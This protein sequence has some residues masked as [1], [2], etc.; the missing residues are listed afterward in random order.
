LNGSAR[1]RSA[2]GEIETRRRR[3]VVLRLTRTLQVMVQQITERE[4]EIAQALDARPDGQIL[5]SFLSSPNSVICAATLLAEI[6]D[7]R[8]RYHYPHR[9]AI[10]ADGGQ[11][12]VAI[13]SGQAQERQV[14]V[15]AQ[16]TTAQR[17][18]HAGA[19]QP[20]NGPLGGRPLRRGPR[21]G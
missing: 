15:G 20:A 3:S 13:E 2:A 17:A 5:R 14:P 12:P 6:G 19:Q 1:P 4:A 10:A 18:R 8:R 11:A 9:D 7:C 21:L 16:Q